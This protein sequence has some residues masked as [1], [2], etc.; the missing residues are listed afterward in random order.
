MI[1]V[2][3]A[4]PNLPLMYAPAIS[5]AL[6]NAICKEEGVEFKL[7]ETTD[8]TDTVVNRH[9]KMASAGGNRGVRKDERDDEY[10]TIKPE[11]R[12]IPDFVETV[13]VYQPDIIL[14]SMQEDVY[15]IG[16][17]LLDSIKDKNIPHILG[18]I[19]AIS[20]PDVLIS[21]PLVNIICR[22]EGEEVVRQALRAMKSGTPLTEIE[23]I[24]WKDF[25]GI[26]QKNRP[27][28][29]TDI[30]KT[31]PDFSCYEAR[32]W[33]RP[34]GGRHFYRAISM[35]TY[36]GCPYKCTYCNSPT[37]R[38]ISKMLNTGN[39]LR[40][41]PADIVDREFR[42][43][44]DQGADPDFCM[45]I[46]DSFLA[47]PAKEI[48]EFCD[49]WSEHRTPFW[50]NTRIENC[51]PEYLEALKR[52]GVYRMTFG[53]ESGN[54]DYR[55][56][57]LKR[58]VTNEAYIKY[59]QY[60]NESDIPYSLNII[61]G[62]PYETREMVLDTARMVYKARG[63]DG[64]T[65]SVFRPYQGTEL[66]KMA[67][68]AG[69]LRSNVQTDSVGLFDPDHFAL[70]MPKPYLQ[71]DEV[72]RLA[73]TFSLYAYYPEEMWDKVQRAETDEQLYDELMATYKEQFFG[74]EYQ[75]GGAE[76]ISQFAKFCGKHDASSTYIFEP[77]PDK[78]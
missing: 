28:P 55:K 33:Q 21:N 60:I 20:A 30:T 49:M 29:L 14:M 68:D 59:L 44:I 78:S 71:A 18:G 46:D 35:E 47:R 7:F 52:A 67:E 38:N 50:F 58:N 34:M 73:K 3:M 61:I 4:Y 42:T 56:N 64:L 63:Y 76:K 41:K 37:T 40:R 26:V 65:V 24:W 74:S 77:Y 19:F 10:F 11:G 54:E 1:K 9:I 66:R 51:K 45:F 27:A 69:F 12:I 31:L 48:Y 2:L 17:R 39:F 13:E 22:Y 23:G 6:F 70:N 72:S 62:M 32:R 43:R 5:V 75:V 53:L 16:I 36:R 25:D 8:Y 15:N 57:I